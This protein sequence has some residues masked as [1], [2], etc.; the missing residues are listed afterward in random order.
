MSVLHVPGGEGMRYRLCHQR[1]HQA[2]PGGNDR[3]SRCPVPR[4]AEMV[5]GDADLCAYHAFA[6]NG[7]SREAACR[8]H[9]PRL[10]ASRGGRRRWE[11]DGRGSF[12]I[13][14]P[15][16]VVQGVGAAFALHVWPDLPTG[17]IAT[18]P[19]P[20]MAGVLSFK[21]TIRGRGGHA[22]MPHTHVNPVIAA[23]SIA[24]Q[25]RSTVTA[26]LPPDEPVRLDEDLL[27]CRACYATYQYIR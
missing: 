8:K 24:A 10:P 6:G 19:G 9:T 1:T 4:R 3:L 20:I 11:A 15:A 14:A 21:A 18:R 22:A 2:V 27:P 25:L 13:L 5:H 26:T 17:V 23:A 16:A 12:H 7:G